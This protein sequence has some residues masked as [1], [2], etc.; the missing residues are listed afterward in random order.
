MH[1]ELIKSPLF[2]LSMASKELFHSNMLYW[3]SVKYP[4]PFLKILNYLG[5]DTSSWEGKKWV[6][7]REKNHFDLSVYAKNGNNEECLLIVENKVKSIPQMYQL[8]KYLTK[9]T[10]KTQL[11]LLSLC[12]E[13]CQK[14]DIQEKW[15]IASY[16]DL[17]SAIRCVLL[18]IY[19]PYHHALLEDYCLYIDYLHRTQKNWTIKLEDYY[20]KTFVNSDTEITKL[21]DVRKKVLISQM[22]DVLYSRY[23]Q[24]KF[25]T[26]KE[27]EKAC[28]EDEPGQVYINTG[29]SHTTAILDVKIRITGNLVY[30]IQLQGDQFRHCIEVLGK[31][32]IEGIAVIKTLKSY[33]KGLNG[34]DVVDNINKLE[35]L[36]LN[37]NYLTTV[38]R[39]GGRYGFN[40]TEIALP[41]SRNEFCQFGDAFVYQYVLIKDDVTIDKIIKVILTTITD[42]QSNIIEQNKNRH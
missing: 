40:E 39:Q 12:T 25:A 29:M 27:I 16:S 2:N 3:I 23:T 8:E 20:V 33:L 13:F 38:Q 19:N 32:D 24:A 42:L 4:Q 6:V 28:Q 22:A 30:V 26:N 37:G 7:Y 31:N 17:S 11:L 9:K 36:I 35:S 10:D 18:Q 21:D 1:D 34:K 5:I 15:K 41:K 14:S